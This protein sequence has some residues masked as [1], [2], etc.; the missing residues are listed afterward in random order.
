MG[1]GGLCPSNESF[2]ELCL[3]M[4][5][6]FLL[7]LEMVYVSNGGEVMVFKDSI[8]LEKETSGSM[9]IKTNISCLS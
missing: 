9:G 3:Q 2:T 6:S 1:F 7:F 8:P 5:D 4:Q